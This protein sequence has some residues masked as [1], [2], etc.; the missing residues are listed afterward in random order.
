VMEWP[1]LLSDGENLYY[2]SIWDLLGIPRCA[3]NDGQC[4]GEGAAEQFAEKVSFPQ[5][6]GEANV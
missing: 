3:R 2:S 4:K 6:D 5:R 1:L